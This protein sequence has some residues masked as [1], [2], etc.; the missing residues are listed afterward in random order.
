[1]GDG[2]LFNQMGDHGRLAG[3]ETRDAGVSRALGGL[4]RVEVIVGHLRGV[5]CARVADACLCASSLRQIGPNDALL[6]LERTPAP[7]RDQDVDNPKSGTVIR[8]GVRID[9]G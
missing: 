4:T 7:E 2:M 1:M 3:T 8:E 6:S 5:S 9:C